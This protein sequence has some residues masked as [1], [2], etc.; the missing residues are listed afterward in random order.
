MNIQEVRKQYPQYSDLT[1]E[2]LGRA[3]HSKYYADMPFDQFAAK[4]GI[5]PAGVAE[6]VVKS[7][8]AAVPKGVAQMYGLPADI[9]SGLA[10]VGEFGAAKLGGLF[11]IPEEAFH[12]QGRPEWTGPLTSD[13]LRKQVEKVVPYQ[14]KTEAGKRVGGVV[15]ALSGGVSMGGRALAVPSILSGMGAEGAGMATGDN[16]WA[17]LAGSFLAPA[18]VGTHQAY[19]STPG[20]MVKEASG[21]LTPQQLADAKAKMELARSKGIDLAGPEAL[22]PSGIQQLMSDVAASPTGG[23]VVNEFM[24]KRPGQV[25]GAVNRELLDPIGKGTPDQNMARARE[26]ATGVIEGAEKARTAA[27]RPAYQAARKDVVPPENIQAIVN[28]INDALPHMSTE[29]QAAAVAFKRSIEGTNPTA[30]AL[31]DLYRVTRNKIEL[32][33]IGATS[34]QKT[35]SAAL[36]PFNRSLDD[37]LKL[38]SDNI[39]SGREQYRQI[40]EDVINPL[41]AGPVG[42]V[43]GKQG[44]DPALPESLN[45]VSAIANEKIARPESIRELYTHLNK[46]DPQAFPGVAR[47]WLENAFDQAAQKTQAGENRMVGANFVKGVFGTPQQEANF[48]ETMRGVA[49]ASGKNP[50][51][52]A[53]GAQ[54]L[55]EVLQ[56]TGRVPNIGS[57]TGSRINSNQ[58]ASSSQAASV[59]ESISAAPMTGIAQKLRQFAMRGNY[60]ALAEAMTSPDSIDKLAALARYNPTTATAQWYAA[61]ILLSASESDQ[62]REGPPQ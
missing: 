41:T 24:A 51:K 25:K 8:A 33:A 17:R 22:P 11:G 50:D 9:L 7:S 15:E 18:G 45:P 20:Q 53:K 19:R 29:S 13:N 56:L 58:L 3:L 36:A 14:P 47:T 21:N 42:R 5:K 31:D 39:R 6:D 60:K 2:Q 38:S 27:V 57:P 30:A 34:A 12:G 43:A 28:Q 23:R 61:G 16:P 59:A 54:T 40:T 26:A 37:S 49:M 44:F 62:R 35:E 10:S 55:L 4:V 48:A 46:Q 52:V 1:D 32:P